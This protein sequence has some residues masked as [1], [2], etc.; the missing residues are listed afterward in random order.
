MGDNVIPFPQRPKHRGQR[1]ECLQRYLDTNSEIQWP[2][3]S[4]HHTGALNHGFGPELR[5]WTDLIATPAR[6]S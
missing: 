2:E 3:I 6:R 4:G 5:P 1:D